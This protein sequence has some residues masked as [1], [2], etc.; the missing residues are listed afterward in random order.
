M[1]RSK[2]RLID[3]DK[4]NGEILTARLELENGE[5]VE[6]H[7]EVYCWLQP[8]Y[9]VGEEATRRMSLPPVATYGKIK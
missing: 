3:Y 6:G 4:G 8:P 7:Y 1:A 2:N 9:E 5:V